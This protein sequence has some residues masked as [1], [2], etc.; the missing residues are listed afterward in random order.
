MPTVD[1]DEL[2]KM[3]KSGRGS[4]RREDSI[5]RLARGAA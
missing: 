4:E 2:A 5:D 3:D 1:I